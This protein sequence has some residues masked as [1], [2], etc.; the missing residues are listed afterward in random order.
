MVTVTHHI[1][2]EKLL[3]FIPEIPSSFLSNTETRYAEPNIIRKSDTMTTYIGLSRIRHL[4]AKPTFA[5]QPFIVP[6][7]CA[8]GLIK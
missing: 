2:F 4:N 6:T 1:A 3:R 7:L 5:E 8:L